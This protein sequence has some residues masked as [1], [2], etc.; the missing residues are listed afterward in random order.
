MLE[1]LQTPCLEGVNNAF[2]NQFGISGLLETWIT[3]KELYG[4]ILFIYLYS[5]GFFFPHLLQLFSKMPL[6]CFSDVLSVKVVELLNCVNLLAS[7]HPSTVKVPVFT[8]ERNTAHAG[9]TCP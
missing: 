9:T 8:E 7:L 6:C 4:V 3:Q 1:P 2:S 5:M